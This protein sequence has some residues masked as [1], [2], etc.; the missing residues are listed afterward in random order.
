MSWD[1]N[2]LIDNIPMRIVVHQHF[3][4]ITLD[5]R[6]RNDEY[7]C[8]YELAQ[9]LHETIDMKQFQ[10]VVVSYAFNRNCSSSFK[11]ANVKRKI[12]S[13]PTSVKGARTTI[14]SL[15]NHF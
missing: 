3:V 5:N 6:C 14:H 11:L 13:S 4:V 8:F 12:L 7:C 1:R 9:Y 2:R 15:A 10:P